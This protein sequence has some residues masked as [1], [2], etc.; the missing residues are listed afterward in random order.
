MAE[1]DGKAGRVRALGCHARRVV[2]GLCE[3]K[4]ETRK[5]KKAEKEDEG[6]E[7]GEDEKE[8]EED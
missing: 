6:E 2:A 5:Q 4:R 8:E 3:A 7:D 1:N